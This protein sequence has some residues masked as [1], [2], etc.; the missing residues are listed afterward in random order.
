MSVHPNDTM[1]MLADRSAESVPWSPTATPALASRYTVLVQP[2]LGPVAVAENASGFGPAVSIGAKVR[3]AEFVA[4]EESSLLDLDPCGLVV[5][6]TEGAV[7]G[8]V[9]VG[10][11]DAYLADG[12]TPRS[13]QMGPMDNAAAGQLHGRHTTPAAFV[14]C[15]ARDCGYPNQLAFFDRRHPPPCGNP[16]LPGHSLQ[17][18]GSV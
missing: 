10:V 12:E 1:E 4:A 5:V 6:D 13:R 17:I 2:G 15:A 8:V 16:E 3:L 11:I 9:P 7:L 14:L 18:A